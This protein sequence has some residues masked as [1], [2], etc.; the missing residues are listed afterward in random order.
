MPPKETKIWA[1]ILV[2]RKN[3]L[4]RLLRK[5]FADQL[6]AVLGTQSQSGPYGS[7]VAFYATDDFKHLMFA[8]TSP[9][10]WNDN[11]VSSA[12]S[13]YLFAQ[14]PSIFIIQLAIG[15]LIGVV[16]SVIAMRKYLKV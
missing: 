15:T 8:T 2:T 12:M 7:L 16:G 14:A 5:L 9:F 4:E 13:S 10:F 3:E 6:L 11:A 1:R